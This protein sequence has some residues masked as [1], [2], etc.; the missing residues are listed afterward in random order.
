MFGLGRGDRQC[1]TLR[2]AV[3]EVQRILIGVQPLTRDCLQQLHV[4]RRVRRP[5][6]LDLS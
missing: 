5:D 1:L 2:L 4:L 6:V 3:T